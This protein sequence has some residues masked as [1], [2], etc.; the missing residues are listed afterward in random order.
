MSR[1]SR[2]RATFGRSRDPPRRD[3]AIFPRSPVG[4]RVA[5]H[6]KAVMVLLAFGFRTQSN[7]RDEVLS[8]VDEAVTRLRQLPG[9]SRGRVFADNDDPDS[10][11]LLSEFESIDQ[12]DVFLTSP[13]F[14]VLKGIRM[15]L[16]DEPVVVLDDVRTRLTRLV[17]E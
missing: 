3:V 17:R 14:Q 6:P 8:A 5:D 9:C 10:F 4:T 12:A 1:L 13:E 2:A 7:K 15:L 11:T 16:R